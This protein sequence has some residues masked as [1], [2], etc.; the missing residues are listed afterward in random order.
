MCML[1]M[2]LLSSDSAECTRDM[3]SYTVA[4]WHCPAGKN[5]HE[6]SCHF[7]IDQRRIREWDRKYD[8][9]LLKQNF[10]KAKTEITRGGGVARTSTSRQ[11]LTVN[12][13]MIIG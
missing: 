5:V 3:H 9:R 10:G 8:E 13:C 1:A 4:E 11:T 6:T 2:L 12:T 7:G